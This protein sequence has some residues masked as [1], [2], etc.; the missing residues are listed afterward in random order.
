MLH[1]KTIMCVFGRLS[2][3]LP[4]HFSYVVLLISTT[5]IDLLGFP[6]RGTTQVV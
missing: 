6:S 5:Q 1:E 2:T 3:W 4:I